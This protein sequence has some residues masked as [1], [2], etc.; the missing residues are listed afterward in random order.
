MIFTSLQDNPFKKKIN[1]VIAM[2][3]IFPPNSFVR[4]LSHLGLQCLP[5]TPRG[6][7]FGQF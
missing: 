4:L 1:V 7:H 6:P 5:L 2:V 3:G